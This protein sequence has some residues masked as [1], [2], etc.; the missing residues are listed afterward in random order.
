MFSHVVSGT[1]RPGKSTSLGVAL[2]TWER[3]SYV[4]RNIRRRSKR[5]R[6]QSKDQPVP[7]NLTFADHLCLA[8]REAG[9]RQGI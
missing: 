1:R 5:A 9:A 8:V 3:A 2:Q 7:A 4:L 6:T